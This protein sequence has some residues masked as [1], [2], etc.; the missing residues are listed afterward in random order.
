[1]ARGSVGGPTLNF[2]Y[3]SRSLVLPAYALAEVAAAEY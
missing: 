3:R 1:M 2:F